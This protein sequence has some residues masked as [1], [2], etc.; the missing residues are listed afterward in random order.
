MNDYHCGEHYCDCFESELLEKDARIKELEDR[1]NK[2]ESVLKQYADE[3]NWI[4]EYLGGRT[5]TFKS[6]FTLAVDNHGYELAQEVLEE[7]E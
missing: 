2:V 3:D 4:Q 1:N 7:K 5:T 6:S